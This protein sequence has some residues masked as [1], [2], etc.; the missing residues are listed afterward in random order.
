MIRSNSI[1]K[2]RT[3]SGSLA[4]PDPNDLCGLHSRRLSTARRAESAIGRHSRRAVC[5]MQSGPARMGSPYRM[6]ART[7]V[8]SAGRGI[9][10]LA[11]GRGA[12][13]LDRGDDRFRQDDHG[14]AGR[15]LA[16]AP[17]RKRAGV[18]RRRRRSPHPDQGRG[19]VRAAAAGRRSCGRAVP[20]TAGPGAARAHTRTISGASWLSVACATGRQSSWRGASCRTR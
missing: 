11:G 6:A 2:S 13:D 5:G 7:R 9:V 4:I 1:D 15:G 17:R 12:A 18:L 3:N 16:G 8:E 20:R 14:N 10:A 19:P